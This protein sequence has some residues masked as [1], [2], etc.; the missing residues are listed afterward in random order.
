MP[1]E[2]ESR[3]DKFIRYL[4]VCDTIKEASR[5]AGYSKYMAA[6]GCYQIVKKPEFQKK[7]K[8]YY[9][10]H[11]ST[12][13]PK[14]IKAESKLVDIVL[15]DPEKLSKHNKTIRELKQST[16]VLQADEAPKQQVININGIRE[17]MIQVNNQKSDMERLSDDQ[18]VEGEVI[19][20]NGSTEA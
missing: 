6:S 16:G 1:A 11:N 9:L 5:R 12:L 13:L 10:A 2:A 20:T 14:I 17:L 15:A 7:L 4:C 18:T 19:D 8:E 3:E